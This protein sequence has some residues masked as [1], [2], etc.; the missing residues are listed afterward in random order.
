M[1]DGYVIPGLNEDYTLAGAKIMEWVAGV[2]AGLMIQE[3]FLGGDT[4]AMPLVI[5]SSVFVTL[6]LAGLRR[7]Y[8][9]EERGLRNQVMVA[10]GFTPP[11]LPSPAPLQPFWS[12]APMRRAAKESYFERLGLEEMLRPTVD[13][14]NRER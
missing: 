9:D 13:P 5:L 7:K 6:G 4:R 1:D 10:L 3:F 12:G 11:G 2:T 14:V 8:P